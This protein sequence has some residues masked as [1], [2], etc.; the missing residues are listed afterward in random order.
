MSWPRIRIAVFFACLCFLLLGGND[1]TYAGNPAN[2]PF[3]STT[4]YRHVGKAFQVQFSGIDQVF[5]VFRD[6]QLDKKGEYLI[7]DEVEEEDVNHLIARKY[8]SLTRCSP[9]LHI[10]V[11]SSL[12][13]CFKV[14]PS[15]NGQLSC[16]YIVQRTLRI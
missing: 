3:P 8:K 2:N 7:T 5:S 13:R 9:S 15:A 12:Y 14:S 4:Q 16:K 10:S 11:L 6:I 1:R